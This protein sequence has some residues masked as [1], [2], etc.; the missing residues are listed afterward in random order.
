MAQLA[1]GLLSM[2]EVQGSTTA[3]T[4][5]VAH[6]CSPRTGEVDAGGPRDLGHPKVLWLRLACAI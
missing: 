1:E 5:I 4:G 3:Q 2:Y 6:V